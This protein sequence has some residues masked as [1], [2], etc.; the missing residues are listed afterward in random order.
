MCDCENTALSD[1]FLDL[2]LKD[3]NLSD[4]AVLK[5]CQ[6]KKNGR[7][8]SLSKMPENTYEKDA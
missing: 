8:S 7:K 4:D 2:T 6:E 3:H 1:I 5:L